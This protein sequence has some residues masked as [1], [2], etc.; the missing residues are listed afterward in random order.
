M[1]VIGIL[2]VVNDVLPVKIACV[3]NVKDLD[4][5]FKSHPEF[6]VIASFE[7]GRMTNIKFRA[8]AKTD[9]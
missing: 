8:N 7:N 4:S 9:Y 3:K 1:E 6:F 2:K 5:L